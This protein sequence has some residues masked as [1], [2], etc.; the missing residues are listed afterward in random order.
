MMYKIPKITTAMEEQ[1]LIISSSFG[2]P[3]SNDIQNTGQKIPMAIIPSPN[4][5]LLSRNN[6]WFVYDAGLERGFP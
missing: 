3:V 2:A 6:S 4:L 1:I 5:V